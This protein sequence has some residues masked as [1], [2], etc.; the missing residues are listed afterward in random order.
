LLAG[1]AILQGAGAFLGWQPLTIAFALALPFTLV[2]TMV[3]V[4]LGRHRAVPAA[5]FFAPAVLL[6]WLGWPWIAPLVQPVL[7]DPQR[8]LT[9]GAV[10]LSLVLGLAFLMRL[11]RPR[12]PGLGAQS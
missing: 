4:V 7:F 9:T 8:L 11:I 6:A 12:Q 1:D 5:V 10:S 3:P 2:F